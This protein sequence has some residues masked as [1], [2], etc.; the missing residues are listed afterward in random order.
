MEAIIHTLKAARFAAA[1]D[2][3]V[4]VG[5]DFAEDVK[6]GMRT[7]EDRLGSVVSDRVWCRFVRHQL[8][9]YDT[10]AEV[11]GSDSNIWERMPINQEALCIR[12]E[13]EG[14]DSDD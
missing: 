6:E 14:D 1:E 8:G 5:L 10:I 3:R 2:R 4:L 9:G 12:V 11:M 13:Y 7:N